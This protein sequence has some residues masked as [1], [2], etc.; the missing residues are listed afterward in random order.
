MK[1]HVYFEIFGKKL[2][3][4]IEAKSFAEAESRVRH[5]IIIHKIEPQPE[6]V[7]GDKTIDHLL[8][9]IQDICKG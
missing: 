9:Q 7:T 6:K 8:G 4:S 1:H 3:A 2:K 5:A